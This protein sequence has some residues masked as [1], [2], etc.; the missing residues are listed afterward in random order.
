M[1][2]IIYKKKEF[3][4]WVQNNIKPTDYVFMTMDMVGSVTANEKK[5]QKS[6]SFGFAADAWVRKGDVRDLAFRETPS[7][8]FA[9]CAPEYVSDSAKD[10]YKQGLIELKKKPNGKNKTQT[11]KRSNK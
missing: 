9:I 7:V 2:T 10:I 11:K 3:L 5:N 4:K 1:S 6:V 8:C